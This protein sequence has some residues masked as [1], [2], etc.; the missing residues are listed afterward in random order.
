MQN[1]FNIKP[2]VVLNKTGSLLLRSLPHRCVTP[3]Y[4]VKYIP[5]YARLMSH[6]LNR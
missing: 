4:I 6:T 2:L 5:L 3:L 1:R